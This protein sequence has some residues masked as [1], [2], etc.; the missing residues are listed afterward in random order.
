MSERSA[1][2]P[3]ASERSAGVPP[4]SGLAW[5]RRFAPSTGKMP[6][7]LDPAASPSAGGTPALL[8]NWRH[9]PSRF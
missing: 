7:L 5:G 6:V 3:P 8:Q 9:A 4:A 1:G 2:V